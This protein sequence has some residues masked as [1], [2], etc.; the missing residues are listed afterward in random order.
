MNDKADDKADDTITGI[1]DTTSNPLTTGHIPCI[2]G[3]LNGQTRRGFAAR[4]AQMLHMATTPQGVIT[5]HTY[6]QSRFGRGNVTA[7]FWVHPDAT[8]HELDIALELAGI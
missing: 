4:N 3:P 6:H 5:T 7:A 2:G 1:T 8:D